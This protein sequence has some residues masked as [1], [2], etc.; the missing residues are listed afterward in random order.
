MHHI[1]DVIDSDVT[2]VRSGRHKN[3]EKLVLRN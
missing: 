1:G 2:K 3:D